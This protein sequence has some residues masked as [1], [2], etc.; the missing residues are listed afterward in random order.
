MDRDTA[1]NW[2]ALLD[3]HEHGS[4]RLPLRAL[5]IIGGLDKA[6]GGPS[7]SVPRLCEALGAAGLEVALFSVAS[8]N[9]SEGHE[10][11]LYGDRRFVATFEHIPLLRSLRFSFGL[12]R[13]LRKRISETDVVHSHGLW[14]LPNLEAAWVAGR[15]KTPLVV[16][17]RGMLGAP[18]LAFSR[19][20]KRIFSKLFQERAIRDADCFHATSAQEYQEI[21]QFGIRNP[22]AV[23]PNGI[24][25]PSMESNFSKKSSERILVTIGRVHPK[26]GLDRLL[27]AWAEVE[28]LFPD[29]RLRII[30]PSESGYD[31]ELRKLASD[32][33][34][35]RV[36]IEPAVYDSN[37]KYN[38][39]GA[40]DIFVLPSLNENFAL[41]VAEALSAGTPVIATKGTPWSQLEIEGCGWWIDS[42]VKPLVSI[43]KFAMTISRKELDAMGVRGRSWMAR[44]FQW[45]DAARK[46]KAVYM[47]ASGKSERPSFV[48]LD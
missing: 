8:L 17:P 47:W 42:G 31:S 33:K 13:A 15:R 12:S 45:N 2:P 40:A 14:L 44:E 46:M 35:A 23:I 34:L 10:N 18:A 29:W 41:T 28:A 21:R 39:L 19:R 43:L 3:R 11:G 20:K 5:H 26:K 36:T 6:Y 48:Y 27:Y 22:V 38:V 24:D 16:A 25:L 7:Y 37:E 4:S 9:S 30:G 32:L 1:T